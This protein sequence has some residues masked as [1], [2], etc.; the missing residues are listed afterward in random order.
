MKGHLLTTL[1]SVLGITLSLTLTPVVVHAQATAGPT[2]VTV[3]PAT[4]SGKGVLS[5]SAK[6]TGPDGKPLSGQ[7]IDFYVPVELFGSREA[8]IGS[9]TTDSTGLA[10]LG[11]Q[12][13]QTG[14]QTIVARF[15][16]AGSYAASDASREIQVNEAVPVLKDEPLPFVGL[17]EWLPLALLALVLGV[18]GVLLGVFLGTVRGIRRAAEAE[19]A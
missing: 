8:F 2:T 4:A 9:A 17:R 6:L 13:A 15:T 14:R 7:E 11:Y 19:V 16:G 18:W 5:L 10:T 12:P 3:N 1:C